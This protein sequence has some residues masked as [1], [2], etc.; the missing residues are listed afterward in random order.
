MITHG[1]YTTMNDN[2]YTATYRRKLS[3]QQQLSLDNQLNEMIKH[4]YKF[5]NYNGLRVSHLNQLT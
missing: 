4:K 5:I 2:T 1:I 3:S